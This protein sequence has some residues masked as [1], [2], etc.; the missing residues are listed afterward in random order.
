MGLVGAGWALLVT[1]I[2]DV[3]W[4]FVVLL[5]YLQITSIGS[6][7]VK[8]YLKPFLVT[9][10]IAIVTFLLKPFTLKW[11]GLILVGAAIGVVFIFLG[12]IL[13]AFGETEKRALKEIVRVF[14][15]KDNN[16]S[17]S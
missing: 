10:G 7:L 5:S 12:F 15:N 16:L 17:H 4:F 6:F 9:I 14:K 2:V 8:A 11:S 3:I 1:C 13:G